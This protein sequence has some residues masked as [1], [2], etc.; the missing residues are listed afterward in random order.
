[1]N[2]HAMSSKLVA[3][4]NAWATPPPL[5]ASS[6]A[7]EAAITDPAVRRLCEPNVSSQQEDIGIMTRILEGC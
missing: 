4:R 1:M 2:E 5:A 7:Q 3:I 6:S